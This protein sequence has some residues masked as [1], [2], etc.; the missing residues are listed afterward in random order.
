[1]GTLAGA[2]FAGH[3]AVGV[4][5]VL[6]IVTGLR[7]VSKRI[8]ALRKRTGGGAAT[9][10]IRVACDAKDHAVV[11]TALARHATGNHSLALTGITARKKK[12]RK[13]VF[14]V[15]HL[16]ADPADDRAVQEIVSRLMIEPGVTAVSWEKLPPTE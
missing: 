3:A 13:R 12:G 2:G 8:D 14:L 10:Q 4:V 7:P 15:A 5:V 9:Y 11:R 6:L 1:M 16:Q